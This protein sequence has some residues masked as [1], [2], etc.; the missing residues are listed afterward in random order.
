M[1]KMR[2]I[3]KKRK[4][5][6]KQIGELVGASESAVSMWENGKHQPDL[7]TLSRIADILSVTTDELLG[8]S[9]DSLD[10]DTMQIRERL[11]SDPNYRLLFSAANNASPEHLKAAAAMLKALEP[12]EYDD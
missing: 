9:D 5:T 12:E 10:N 11:R 8:R 7:Q 6:M 4:M 3:R 2:E 1:N